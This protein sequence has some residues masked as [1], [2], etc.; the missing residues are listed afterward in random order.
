MKNPYEVEATYEQEYEPVEGY[1]ITVT[2]WSD[3]MFTAYIARKQYGFEDVLMD[4]ETQ[5]DEKPSEDFLA[6]Y[7]WERLEDLCG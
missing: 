6:E 7:V 1:K 2:R 3:G 5:W 4:N